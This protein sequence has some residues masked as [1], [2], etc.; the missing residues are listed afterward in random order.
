M[1]KK[2]S[3]KFK[4]FTSISIVSLIAISTFY[5]YVSSYYKAGSFAIDQLQSDTRVTVE[6]QGDISFIPIGDAENRGVIFY[7][8]AKVEAAA[9]APLAKEIAANGYPVII[10]KMRFNLA[11]LSP[12]RADAIIENHPE[13]DSWVIVG[14]SLGGVM[15]ADY[16][17]KNEKVKGLV[18][19]ASYPQE[20]TDLA[21]ESIKVLSLWGNLDTVADL[22]KVKG[23][24]DAM[25]NDASFIELTGG[26]HS[27]F[28][29]YGHQKGDGIST[30]TNKQQM[31][32]TSKYIL[33]ILD[34]HE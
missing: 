15:A 34:G 25:P 5:L 23:A 22:S 9:Y 32:D 31:L 21:N 30:I 26:N 20:K 2:K 29:D 11:I 18:L 3:L 28:G 33:E 13:I 17:L 8:G 24:K 19:L 4:V 27:G 16:A 10:A 7:P 6:N 14:H 1:K 12:N